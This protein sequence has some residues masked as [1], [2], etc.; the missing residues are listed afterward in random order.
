MVTDH[1]LRVRH[2]AGEDM[3]YVTCVEVIDADDS[4]GRIC[5]TNVFEKQDGKW[6]IV[7]HHGS[8]APRARAS[9]L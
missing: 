3:G 5:A 8:V 4:F 6:V 1:D 2:V 9:L 7:M